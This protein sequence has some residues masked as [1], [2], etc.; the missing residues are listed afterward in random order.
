MESFNYQ[1]SSSSSHDTKDK[2][3]EEKKEESPFKDQD[4]LSAKIENILRDS[5]VG[6]GVA[7]SEILKQLQGYDES[8]IDDVLF[9]LA[10]E[11]KVYQPKPDYYKIMD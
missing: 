10:Y 7:F 6:D 3:I 5:D 4:S 11:G 2:T 8:E 1:S 9:E